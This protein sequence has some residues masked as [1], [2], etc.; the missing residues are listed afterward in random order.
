[1]SLRLLSSFVSLEVSDE[2][3]LIRI[4][5]LLRALSGKSNRP[6]RGV[7][8]L[9]TLDFLLRYPSAL[10]RLLMAV[11]RDPQTA[12]VAQTELYNLQDRM[13]ARRFGPWDPRYRRWL[14]LLRS[15]DCVRTYKDGRTATVELTESGQGLAETASALESFRTLAVRAK[16]VNTAFGTKS[17]PAITTLIRNNI[18]EFARLSPGQEILL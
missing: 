13:I 1:M 17:Q 15:R 3:H 18:P 12:E 7:G 8:K 16:L 11:G 9:A 6:T 2:L 10:E 4:L 5:V 14:A